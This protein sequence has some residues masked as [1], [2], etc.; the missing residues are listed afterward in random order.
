MCVPLDTGSLEE[1]R[2]KLA[3]PFFT[4]TASNLEI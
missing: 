3:N 1:G 2:Q 4:T